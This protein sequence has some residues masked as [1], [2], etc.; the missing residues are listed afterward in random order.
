MEKYKF[1]GYEHCSTLFTL[2]LRKYAEIELNFGSFSGFGFI[3][4]NDYE[5]QIITNT[6]KEC[7]R[8]RASAKRPAVNLRAHLL[9]TVEPHGQARGTFRYARWAKS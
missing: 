3:P 7:R 1:I 6:D 5:C 9:D 4:Y 8:L 2:K